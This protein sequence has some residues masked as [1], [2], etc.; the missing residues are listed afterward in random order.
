[1]V[2]AIK[3]RKNWKSGNTEVIINDNQ[4]ANVYL[5]GNLISWVTD[6]KIELFDGGWQTPTTKSRLNAIIKS[7]TD[8][9]KNGV[10]QLNYQWYCQTNGVDYPFEEVSTIPLV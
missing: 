9:T 3:C 8:G 6:E 1:M 4:C 5:H 10:Y 7:L 2:D